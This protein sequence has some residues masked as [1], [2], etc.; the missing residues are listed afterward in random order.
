MRFLLYDGS[1]AGAPAVTVVFSQS[2]QSA[3]KKSTSSFAWHQCTVAILDTLLEFQEFQFSILSANGDLNCTS[4]DMMDPSL[5]L[6]RS[7]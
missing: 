4:S 6:L 3:K 5:V 2:N 1:S 7:R